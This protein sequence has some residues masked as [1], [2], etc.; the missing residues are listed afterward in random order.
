MDSCGHYLRADTINSHVRMRFHVNNKG[1][2]KVATAVFAAHSASVLF[3]VIMS[4]RVHYT[5]RHGA[6]II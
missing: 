5:C 3:G 4:P 2:I 1:G 6:D